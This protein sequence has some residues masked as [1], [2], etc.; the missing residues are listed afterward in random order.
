MSDRNGQIRICGSHTGQYR[1]STSP[2][3]FGRRVAVGHV[4]HMLLGSAEIVITNRDVHNIIV[5]VEPSVVV[6]GDV[7]FENDGVDLASKFEDAPVSILLSPLGRASSPVEGATLAR[8]PAP[9][10][11]SFPDIPIDNYVVAGYALG[12]FYVKDIQYGNVS[13][14]RP[15]VLRV[16]SGGTNG[17]KIIVSRVGSVIKGKVSDREGNPTPFATIFIVPADVTSDS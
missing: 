14:L 7:V 17:L 11:F 12:P 8:S 16:G 10:S 15:P 4:N 13:I 9:G 1:L 6:K 2:V 5:S 3:P